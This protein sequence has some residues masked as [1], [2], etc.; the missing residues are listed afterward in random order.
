MYCKSLVALEEELNQLS[1]GVAIV[2]AAE[3]NFNNDTLQPI[4]KDCSIPVVGAFFPGVISE[5][6]VHKIKSKYS[7]FMVE[8]ALAMG[9][10]VSFKDGRIE[11]CN[12]TLL[13]SLLY[14][15]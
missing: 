15:Y 14:E 2:L 11:L 7:D 6:K 3:N 5:G 12:R 4:I 1:T 10:I 8:G 13:T 9:E